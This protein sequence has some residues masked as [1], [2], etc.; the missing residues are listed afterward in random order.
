MSLCL[1]LVLMHLFILLCGDI[2]YFLDYS[3]LSS[4]NIFFSFFTCSAN[5]KLS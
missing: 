3:P 4:I 2:V 5:G 1:N